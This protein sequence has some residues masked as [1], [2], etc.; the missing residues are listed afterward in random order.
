MTALLLFLMSLV[1]LATKATKADPDPEADPE[2]DPDP[3]EAEVQA[4]FDRMFSAAFDKKMEEWFGSKEPPEPD[5]E[6]P[7]PKGNRDWLKRIIGF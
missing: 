6:R 5:P 2:G 3:D 7:G 1:G 4:R